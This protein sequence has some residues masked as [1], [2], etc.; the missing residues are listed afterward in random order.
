MRIPNPWTAACAAARAIKALLSS[1]DILAPEDAV[2]E[3]LKKCEPCLFFDPELRQCNK[4]SCFVDVKAQLA[5]ETC[6]EG[7]WKP[8]PLTKTGAARLL[9]QIYDRLHPKN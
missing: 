6:P 8:V 7:R 4:C 3:R 5:T 9:K 1:Q 2:E